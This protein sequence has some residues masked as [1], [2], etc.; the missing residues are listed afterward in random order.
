MASQAA[1][2]YLKFEF[3]YLEN[4]CPSPFIQSS[5]TCDLSV[6]PRTYFYWYNQCIWAEPD[7]Q[8][9]R[10]CS[11]RPNLWILLIITEMSECTLCALCVS[12]NSYIRS[13]FWIFRVFRIQ[14]YF[15]FKWIFWGSLQL[16][17]FPALNLNLIN[18]QE[19]QN[20]FS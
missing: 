6:Y 2:Y 11:F 19:C 18:Y 4:A 12:C 1:N 15:R 9:V 20:S 16:C 13:T 8:Y 10:G 3:K 5:F 14:T 7:N 17:E